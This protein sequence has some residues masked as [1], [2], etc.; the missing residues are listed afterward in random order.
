MIRSRDHNVKKTYKKPL[1]QKN[2][3]IK[4]IYRLKKLTN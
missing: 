3:M 2:P 1:D 4:M